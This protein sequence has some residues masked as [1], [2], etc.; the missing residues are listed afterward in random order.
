MGS[1][2]I[3]KVAIAERTVPA[4]NGVLSTIQ[5][6]KVTTETKVG[7]A[8]KRKATAE[9]VYKYSLN[10]HLSVFL[11][12][13]NFPM[14]VDSHE[15]SFKTLMF[16]NVSEVALTLKSRASI[17]LKKSPI[18]STSTLRKLMTF[19]LLIAPCLIVKDFLYV[20]AMRA[21]LILMPIRS[22]HS[23]KGHQGHCI[24]FEEMAAEHHSALR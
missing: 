11:R 4:V 19:P 13:I 16:F 22:Q 8:Q 1:C 14:N 10:Q 6:P 17:I 24:L 7:E 3:R 9:H 5:T 2:K 20:N 12:S 15:C 18:L 23:L 21:A